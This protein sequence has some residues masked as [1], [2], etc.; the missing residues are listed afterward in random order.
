M[1]FVAWMRVGPLGLVLGHLVAGVAIL[2]LVVRRLGAALRPAL[3]GALLA[4]SL[5]ISLP[6]TPRI[7]LGV[8]GSNFD[9]YL[10]GL[11]ATV[12]GVGVYAVGQRISYMAFQ[13]MT[14]IENVFTPQVYQRTCR[15]AWPWASLSS[16]RSCC[17]CSRQR[18]TTAPSPSSAS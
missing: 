3:D 8:V 17:Q 6:L 1:F 14:A 9:K 16:Q 15:S 13:Y 12:G 7:F 18:A 4:D 2:V 10:I 11:L 5:R